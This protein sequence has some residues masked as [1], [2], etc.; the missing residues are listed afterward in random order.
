MFK[1]LIIPLVVIAVI[2]TVFFSL[3]GKE[4]K[5]HT[6]TEI[7]QIVAESDISY[8]NSI[9]VLETMRDFANSADNFVPLGRFTPQDEENEKGFLRQILSVLVTFFNNTV[10]FF[11]MIG[12]TIKLIVV[13]VLDTL[14]TVTAVLDIF[15]RLIGDSV[16]T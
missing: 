10:D 14:N 13:F 2:G 4:Y 11:V 8:E 6:F 9:E 12:Y 5:P 1:K 7:L 16:F 15:F 3:I